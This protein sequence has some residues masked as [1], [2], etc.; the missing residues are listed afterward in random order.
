MLPFSSLTAVSP[1]DGRYASKAEMLR[2]IFSEYGL[3]KFR[4]TVEV[5]WLQLLAD[6]DGIKEVPALSK[7]ATQ[8]TELHC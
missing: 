5:R 4:V 6:V 3:I 1:V 2:P 7:D 8:S